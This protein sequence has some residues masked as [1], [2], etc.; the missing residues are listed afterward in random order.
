MK[1]ALTAKGQMDVWM[2]ATEAAL[3]NLGVQDVTID[4]GNQRIIGSHPDLGPI[5]IDYL[6]PDAGKT[7]MEIQVDHPELIQNFKHA[8]ASEYKTLAAIIPTQ[9][10]VSPTSPEA[11]EEAAQPGTS[12]MSATNPEEDTVAAPSEA[13]APDTSDTYHEPETIQPEYEE[14]D[15]YSEDNYSPA[16]QDDS[17]AVNSTPAAAI[18]QEETKLCKYCKSPMPADEKVCPSCHKKQKGKGPIIAIIIAG[19][20]VVLALVGWFVIKPKL[21]GSNSGSGSQSTA[22]TVTTTPTASATTTTNEDGTTTTVTTSGASKVT[23]AQYEQVQNG[24][25]YADVVG[26]FGGDGTL[27]S[28]SNYNDESGNPVTL[29]IYYWEG[30][31]ETGANASITFQGDVVTTKSSFGLQ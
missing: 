30:Q 13:A 2:R 10:S 27:L 17:S 4:E 25:S 19:V 29:K 1:Q 23:N 31:G 11:Q 20:V 21:S 5:A 24:M 12:G 26:I 6:I 28:E 15:A 18:P 22:T 8:V 3:N 9:S 7:R 14:P 16:T